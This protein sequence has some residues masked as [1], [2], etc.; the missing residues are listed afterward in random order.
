MTCERA[1]L[2]IDARFRARKRNNHLFS[3]SLLIM[4]ILVP[5]LFKSVSL[6]R[7]VDPVPPVINLPL[8]YFFSFG[9]RIGSAA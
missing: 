7:H 9:K 4:K 6:K 3:L 5:P 1:L 8:K 2:D